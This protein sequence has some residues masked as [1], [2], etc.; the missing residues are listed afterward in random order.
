MGYRNLISLGLKLQLEYF[1]FLRQIRIVNKI[2]IFTFNNTD[3]V[4][5]NY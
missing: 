5:A 3:C 2:G 4:P 1:G